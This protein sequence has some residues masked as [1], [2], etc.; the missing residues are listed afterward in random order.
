[1]LIFDN[2]SLAK[3]TPCLAFRLIALPFSLSCFCNL[4]LSTMRQSLYLVNYHSIVRHVLT[5]KF[6]HTRIIF[7]AHSGSSMYDR[8]AEH[9]TLSCLARL[10]VS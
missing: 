7:R 1:M 8:Q 5:N 2:Q 10:D 9:A 3:D 6:T 4:T